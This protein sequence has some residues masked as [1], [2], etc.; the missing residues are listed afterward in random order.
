VDHLIRD[1][2]CEAMT[3][4]GRP[5]CPHDD[6]VAL[7]FLSRAQDE[8]CRVAV[9]DPSF[10]RY[11]GG[12]LAETGQGIADDRFSGMSIRGRN[13]VQGDDPRPA[14]SGDLTGHLERV[15]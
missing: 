10:D 7:D 1:V 12:D 3:R 9:N 13:D 14:I 8:V 4:P 6:D 2:L 15:A 5:V 11:I